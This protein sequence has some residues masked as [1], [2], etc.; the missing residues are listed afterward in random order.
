MHITAIQQLSLIVLLS[1]SF[2]GVAL[3]RKIKICSGETFSLVGLIFLVLGNTAVH[4]KLRFFSTW[5]RSTT[6]SP[7]CLKLENSQSG[8][9]TLESYLHTRNRWKM[10]KCCAFRYHICAAFRI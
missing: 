4:K 9:L 7:R 8:L 1:S 3:I 5:T 6:I 10:M 2:R